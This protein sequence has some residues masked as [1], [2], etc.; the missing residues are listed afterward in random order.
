MSSFNSVAI[1]QSKAQAVLGGGCFWCVEAVYQTIRGIDSVESGYAGGPAEEATYENVS[2]GASEHAEVVRVNYDPAQ[3]S[4][5][6]ILRIFFH[7]HDPTTLN[8]QGNDVGPQYRSV[9]FYSKPDE[10]KVAEQIKQEISSSGLWKNPIVTSIEPLTGFHLAEEY[11][12]DYFEK[13][14]RQPYCLLVVA[15]KVQNHPSAWVF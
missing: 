8:R 2:S 13:N 9:I 7:L 12:Q 14:P 5:A 4:Y 15:P 3:I 6:D 10:L 1:A 11:H